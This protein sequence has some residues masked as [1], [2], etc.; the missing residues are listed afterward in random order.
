MPVHTNIGKVMAYGQKE[1]VQFPA[2]AEIISSSAIFRITQR[3][4]E[5]SAKDYT[6]RLTQESSNRS[7][8]LIAHILTVLRIKIREALMLPATPTRVYRMVFRGRKNLPSHLTR[9]AKQVQRN[10]EALSC[11]SCCSGKAMSITQPEC[12]FVALDI[13]HAMRMRHIVICGL[14]RSTIFFQIIS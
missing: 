3:F 11:N 2:W 5:S 10:T 12:V 9:H 14:L 1:G 4:R 6:G 13:K 7:V 8:K